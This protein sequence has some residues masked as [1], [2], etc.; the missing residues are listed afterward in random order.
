VRR[1]IG[2]GERGSCFRRMIVTEISVAV[3]VTYNQRHRVGYIEVGVAETAP[4]IS[5]TIVNPKHQLHLSGF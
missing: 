5:A 1:S 3:S 4:L 2:S